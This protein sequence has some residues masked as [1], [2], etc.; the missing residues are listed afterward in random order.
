MRKNALWKMIELQKSANG[1]SS[2][3]TRPRNNS[4]NIEP[5]RKRADVQ[6]TT[7]TTRREL[8]PVSKARWREKRRYSALKKS[9]LRLHLWCGVMPLHRATQVHHS[10]G[11]LGALLTDT[12][13][14]VPVSVEGHA[15]IHANPDKARSTSWMGIPLLCEKGKWNTAT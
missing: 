14:L 13:Y 9:F 1:H 7:R 3:A 8:S 15:W 6:K 4:R 12:R 2:T 10:R 11:R 5:Q